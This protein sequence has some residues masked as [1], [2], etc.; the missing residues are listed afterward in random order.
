[1]YHIVPDHKKCCGTAVR[2]SLGVRV[3]SLSKIIKNSIYLIN[4]KPESFPKQIKICVDSH[5]NIYNSKFKRS[6]NL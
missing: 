6:K 2:L 1:M 3:T 4:T 5:N